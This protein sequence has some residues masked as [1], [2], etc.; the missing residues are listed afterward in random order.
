MH[1]ALSERLVRMQLDEAFQS[2]GLI[3]SQLRLEPL[4]YPTFFVRFTNT[5]AAERLIRFDCTNYDFDA[6]AIE[7]VDPVS[8]APLSA[9]GFM[10]TG[11]SAFPPHHMKGGGPF[12]CISGTRDYYTHE[13]HRPTVSGQR[14]EQMRGDFRIA[15][16]ITTIQSRLTSGVWT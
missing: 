4:V 13:S 9:D 3:A 8:R 2:E 7:P 12:L 10:K 15:D 5:H 14:W 16:L 6:I 1:P 11:G